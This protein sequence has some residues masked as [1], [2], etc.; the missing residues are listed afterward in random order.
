M[1]L[2]SVVKM[3]QM[4]RCICDCVYQSELI[5]ILFILNSLIDL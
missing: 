3:E 1:F 2:N 4:W 5:R